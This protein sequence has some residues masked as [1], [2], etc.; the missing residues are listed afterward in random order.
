MPDLASDRAGGAAQ[1]RS[2]TSLPTGIL[3]EQQGISAKALLPTFCLV[4]WSMSHEYAF[5]FPSIY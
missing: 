5:P 4:L 1:V 2:S 3:L